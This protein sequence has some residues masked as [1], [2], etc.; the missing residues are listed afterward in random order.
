MGPRSP[1]STGSA[2]HLLLTV[3][4]ELVYP[5]DAPVWTASLLYVLTGLGIEESTAR[6]AIARGAAAGWITPERHGREVRWALTD[7]GRRLFE[8]GTR[9]VIS[10]S[11][12]RAAWDGRWL[13]LLITIPQSRRTVRKKLYNALT[14]A[15][16]GNPTPGLWLSP[17]PDRE[18]E[19]RE[20]VDGLGLTSSTLGFVGLSAAVGLGDAEIVQRSWDLADVADTYEAL[21]NKFSG[22]RPEPGDP[23]LLTHIELVSEWQRFP[24]MDPQLPEALLPDW[25]GRRAAALLQELRAGWYDDAQARWRAVV[26]M[27]AGTG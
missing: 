27:T 21:I 5:N 20:V 19:A 22:L 1:M 11:A 7:K 6:Q 4:G 17:H 24:F 14:W 15:G 8:E 18:P 10:L 26:E 25:I 3:L 9:R 12:D 13:I 23:L 16:F 2:R